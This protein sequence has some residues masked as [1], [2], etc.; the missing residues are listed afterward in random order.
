[1]QFIKKVLDFLTVDEQK[2]ALVVMMLIL[3]TSFMDILGVA[4]ILPFIAVLSNPEMISTN[5]LFEY[6][7][8]LSNIIGVSNV[9]QFL[10]FLGVIVFVL[11]LTSLILR[12]LSQYAQLRFA[13][14]REFSI[15]KNLIERYLHQ[16][17]TWFLNQH[18]AELGKSI[19]SEVSAVVQQ[20]I[21]SMLM[22]FAYSTLAI[23]MILL[24]FVVDVKLAFIVSTFL[25]S[26]YGF[27]FYFMKN[28]LSI[29]GN[30]KITANEARFKIVSEAFSAIK[31]IKLAGLEKNYV[32]LFSKPAEIFARNQALSQTISY[33]PR[34]IIE[35][36]AFGGM[37]ILVLVLIAR[38]EFFY[39]IAPILA[40]YAFAGY[41]LIPAIQNIYF[42]I[43]QIRF[44]KPS[45]DLL[46]KNLVKLKNIENDNLNI[47]INFKKNVCLKDIDFYYPFTKEPTLKNINFNISSFSRIGII[48]PS[49]SGKTTLVNIILGL[50]SA[51]KGSLLVDNKII[52]M[53][54]VKAW[55]KNIG[56]VPQQI[57]LSDKSIAENIAFGVKKDNINYYMIQKVS[58][59]AKIHDFV[60]NNLPEKYDSYV[61]EG[62]VKLSG[63][64]RQRIG[65]ARALYHNPSLLILDEAT[66]SLDNITE[67]A[68]VDD[69]NKLEK[70]ITIIMIAHRLTT[71]KNCEQ[72]YLLENNKI[73]AKGNYSEFI[74][75]IKN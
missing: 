20:T 8:Q 59:I 4:S 6:V 7:Y 19:L 46:H 75:N 39:E 16:P 2:K 5:P 18:S 57:Y 35:G 43:T 60:I 24:L 37:I 25:I 29:I 10:F 49:G 3:F 15:G 65:I 63:G 74:K 72:I 47:V 62:G 26:V 27:V 12:A 67:N 40:L 44:S 21:L 30:Q 73:S 71:L 70:N 52:T 1:M 45:L 17:Y 54:N 32:K 38:G 13:L 55:Q 66:S 28:I 23:S 34:F 69:I 48:G 31:E 64:Q 53:D 41:R 9:T 33:L 14:M 42:S 61:G 11:L 58:K 68:V 51:T 56:Y 22:F 36:V 50:Y